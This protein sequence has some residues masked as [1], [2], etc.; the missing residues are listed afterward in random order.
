MYRRRTLAIPAPL[1]GLVS[2]AITI[3]LLMLALAISGC[4]P[5]M[6]SNEETSNKST[7]NISKHEP[8]QAQVYGLPDGLTATAF[9]ASVL[10]GQGV[11]MELGSLKNLDQGRVIHH[12]G[13]RIE[14]A[15][16]HDSSVSLRATQLS[17]TL[18]KRIYQETREAGESITVFIKH[19]EPAP[20][21]GHG[22]QG[23]WSLV[24]PAIDAGSE[25]SSQVTFHIQLFRLSP[26]MQ[27]AVTAH[28]ELNLVAIDPEPET[29]DQD[30]MFDTRRDPLSI[31]R[32]ETKFIGSWLVVCDPRWSSHSVCRSPGLSQAI[33]R[34]ANRAA[35]QLKAWDINTGELARLPLASVHM[36]R[37]A[38]GLTNVHFGDRQVPADVFSSPGSTAYRLIIVQENPEFRA[39]YSFD[40]GA[41]YV[42]TESL[43]RNPAGHF[44]PK[45]SLFGSLVHELVHALQALLMRQWLSLGTET[46][47]M[48]EGTATFMQKAAEDEDPRLSIRAG[49]QRD[50]KLP[51]DEPQD[52]SPYRAFELFAHMGDPVELYAL[53]FAMG[54][55]DLTEVN[56]FDG[57][58]D[59]IFQ[60]YGPTNRPNIID[61]DTN[62]TASFALSRA[63]ATSAIG[64]RA[65]GTAQCTG[66]AQIDPEYFDDARV[67]IQMLPRSS[68]CI[69]F[70]L[71]N[72]ETLD[73]ADCFWFNVYREDELPSDHLVHAMVSAGRIIGDR[74]EPGI[75]VG[76][77]YGF[78]EFQNSQIQLQLTDGD[79]ERAR[80]EHVAYVIQ[81]GVASCSDH[82]EE[83][84][85]A[86]RERRCRRQT[87]RPCAE[88]PMTRLRR[89]VE[90]DT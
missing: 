81:F 27:I 1:L 90:T 75:H 41:I 86:Q 88:G 20:F 36:R 16:S 5:G 43:R 76:A 45:A 13:V 15:A 89:R 84:T 79:L 59:A 14:G 82:D 30:T 47:W 56:T 67:R 51:I 39:A 28:S 78:G 10:D 4:H 25:G 52:Q 24:I 31:H 85:D 46:L 63:L 48:T 60:A 69:D 2:L 70:K 8:I 32:D 74:N 77:S 64:A 42:S 18:D 66:V 38:N 19:D 55:A 57:I 54:A 83:I 80:D 17:F 3:G 12:F 72:F 26:L 23:D 21:P 49:R 29:G 40:N 22:P 65:M 68:Q 71:A 35:G 33:A 37:D 87:N 9:S 58:N 73:E 34:T 6:G 7:K 50:W 61:T 62:N 11:D 53:L 44:E